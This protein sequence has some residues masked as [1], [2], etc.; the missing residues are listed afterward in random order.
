MKIL[1]CSISLAAMLAASAVTAGDLTI[2]TA[3]GDE[4]YG[5]LVEAFEAAHP[6][7]NVEVIVA[8]TGAMFQRVQAES[9]NAAADV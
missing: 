4:I 5:P 7:I 1:S 2:Y 8:D 6:D 3:H 9:G